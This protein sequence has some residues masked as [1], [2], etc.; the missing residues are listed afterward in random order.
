M[1]TA[2]DRPVSRFAHLRSGPDGREKY[3]AKCDEWWPADL[4]FFYSDPR[5]GG[6]LFSCC[7]AC[8]HEHHR[9]NRA[10]RLELLGVPT[11]VTAE[12]AATRVLG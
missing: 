3:C 4:E 7:K 6:G 9:P 2:P 11:H 5:G 8:Y 10:Q 1:S 12:I